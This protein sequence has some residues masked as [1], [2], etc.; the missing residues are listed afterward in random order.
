MVL[1][2]INVVVFFGALG[3]YPL[4]SGLNYTSTFVVRVIFNYW[5]K[6]K[7][8]NWW[9]EYNFVLSCALDVEV[10]LSG[11]LIFFCLQYPGALIIW[12]GNGIF[13][14]TADALGTA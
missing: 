13:D 4:A 11:I 6:R 5:I 7:W 14:N 1:E 10:V 9:S 3:N 8:G 12:W 2:N